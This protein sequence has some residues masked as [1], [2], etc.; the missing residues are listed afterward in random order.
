M[1]SL[2][3]TVTPGRLELRACH[4]QLNSRGAVAADRDLDSDGC[5]FRTV[6][7]SESEIQVATHPAR[8]GG[9]PC[10]SRRGPA[11]ESRRAIVVPSLTI[12]IIEVGFFQV[13]YSSSSGSPGP[14]RAM[15]SSAAHPS[16]RA[17]VTSESESP[18]EHHLPVHSGSPATAQI[19][20]STGFQVISDTVTVTGTHLEPWVM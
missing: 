18:A 11:N 13:E 7:Q 1:T 5:E 16:H 12:G 14:A 3:L 20:S 4:S 9:G 2:R 10:L 17:T 6:T 15:I 8:A 19:S